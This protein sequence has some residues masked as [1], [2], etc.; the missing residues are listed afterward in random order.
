MPAQANHSLRTLRPT[1]RAA[2]SALQ[3]DSG[4]HRLALRSHAAV[5]S[6]FRA[7]LRASLRVRIR[8][9]SIFGERQA[10]TMRRLTMC[11]LHRTRAP[12]ASGPSAKAAH[13]SCARAPAHLVS[14]LMFKVLVGAC[15][16]PQ[17]ILAGHFFLA[18]SAPSAYS[19]RKRTKSFSSS[20]RPLSS[21]KRITAAAAPSSLLSRPSVPP[22]L[23]AG[24][25]HSSIPRQ[26]L[27]V[28]LSAH[29]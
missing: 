11:S 20:T 16:L 21:L 25:T 12:T 6:Q 9:R 18:S 15:R 24:I 8:R 4:S 29:P 19:Q 5:L 27:S 2:S 23:A 10:T 28:S 22:S 1:T 3:P 13:L 7:L 14:L 26:E 17:P